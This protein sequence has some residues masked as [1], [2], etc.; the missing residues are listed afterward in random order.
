MAA[1]PQ[2]RLLAEV[3]AARTAAPEVGDPRTL[4]PQG[5][6]LAQQGRSDMAI[7]LLRQ[8]AT[9]APA[10]PEAHL[11]LGVALMQ[12]GRPA[13][14]E[15]ALRQAESLAPR[16]PAVAKNLGMLLLASG[17]AGEAARALKKAVTL[18]GD[19][20]DAAALL[21]NLGV[22]Q[23]RLGRLDEAIRSFRRAGHADPGLA[24]A[25]K[26]LAL[27]L[28]ETRRTDEALEV[29][30]KGLAR[31]PQAAELHAGRAHALKERGQVAEAMAAIDQACTL[32][33]DSLE[34]LTRR[35]LLAQYQDGVDAGGLRR[36]HGDMERRHGARLRP[37]WRCTTTVAPPTGRPLRVGYVSGDLRR[38]PVGFF[39]AAVLPHHDHAQV[40]PVVY[41]CHPHHDEL[42]AVI[43]NGTAEWHQ[44]H[45]IGDAALADLIHSHRIDI[46]VDLAGHTAHNRLPAFARKPAPVQAT[47]A[48]YVGTT[49]LAAMDW[50]I[51]DRVHVRPGEEAHYGERI[52][53]MPDGYI[54]WSPPAVAPA[55]APLPA[56][57]R[58]H[59]TL[60]GFHNI[61]K[62]GPS[63]VA[64]WAEILHRLP[65]ARL[66]LRTKALGDAGVR[67]R[68][69]DLFAAHGI[70]AGRLTL[71]GEL[72]QDKLMA[73]YGELDIALDTFPYSGGVTTL[74]AM[75]MGVPVVTFPGDSF[76]GRHATS[77]LGTAGHPELVAADRDDYVRRVV[78]LA[79]DLPAL[80]AL[81]ARLRPDL[82]ASPTLDHAA[83][84]RNLEQLYRRL[85]RAG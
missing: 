22:A 2:D 35:L 41:N 30:D 4:I 34:L 71:A 81:R 65:T 40:V 76:A 39:M 42:T 25:C 37:E 31:A 8:A 83:F 13:E 50:L 46:L 67:R 19:G 43:R 54:A 64:T 16:H 82:A 18:E 69:Q 61:A 72:P 84:T 17:P 9:A 36:V 49:G 3:L 11:N 12:A 85:W 7:A 10:L 70:A 21:N 75:W 6:R 14:A 62:L 57:A 77:H 44:V 38:H 66:L 53:R 28:T 29:L 15:A 73:A 45:D 5:V 56:L 58:G 59:V 80:A 60:G 52:A 33:P 24:D 48:G 26:N 79:G 51:A 32:D 78:A 47:W 68:Y 20:P 23:R 63:V 74:E 1:R 55:V 27:T